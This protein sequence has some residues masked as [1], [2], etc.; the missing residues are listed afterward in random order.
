MELVSKLNTASNI[1]KELLPGHVAIIMD[2]S[3]RWAK[4]H[5]IP[6]VAG[7]KKGQARK[8]IVETSIYYGIPYL[9][10]FAY[11]RKTGIAQS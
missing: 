8:E 10:L 7:H 11:Q 3:G 1:P 4:N 6:R 9:T 5:H 2:G